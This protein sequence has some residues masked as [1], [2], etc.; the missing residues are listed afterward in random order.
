MAELLVPFGLGVVELQAD[1]L[2]P[3]LQWVP[4][5]GAEVAEAGCVDV[6]TDGGGVVE[7]HPGA[8]TGQ[9]AQAA[10]AVL[11]LG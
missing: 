4:V 6:E 2:V 9:V 8:G 1:V 11:D 7:Q 10:F 3:H 5:A